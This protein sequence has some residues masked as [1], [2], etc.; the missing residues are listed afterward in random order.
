M[1]AG[2]IEIKSTDGR[3]IDAKILRIEDDSLWVEKDG[4]TIKIPWDKIEA[5]QAKSLKA[6]SWV[7]VEFDRFKQLK[8]GRVGKGIK[9]DGDLDLN[10]AAGSVTAEN[11]AF[12]LALYGQCQ[13]VKWVDD[14]EVAVLLDG[15]PCPIQKTLTK[16]ELIGASVFHTCALR[17]D[18]ETAAKF[19]S[20]SKVELRVGFHELSLPAAAIQRF[21]ALYDWW[22]TNYK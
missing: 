22:T 7:E 12:V 21:G 6:E 17:F 2:G 16:G 1:M 4:K 18:G 19:V 3:V 20:A 10:I 11:P 15:V 5:R 8:T 9:V 13:T 14:S